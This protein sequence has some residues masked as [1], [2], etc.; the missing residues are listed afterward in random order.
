MSLPIFTLSTYGVS[1]AFSALSTAAFKSSVA[2]ISMPSLS[3]KVANTTKFVSVLLVSAANIL[4]MSEGFTC[5][6]TCLSTSY[7]SLIDGIGSLSRK[8]RTYCC[9]KKE[10]FCFSRL[11][12]ISSSLLR[13]SSL[14]RYSSVSVKPNFLA[15]SIST[16][17]ACTASRLLPAFGVISAYSMS[18][19]FE[20]M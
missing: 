3:G 10:F 11:S 8:W 18:F 15:L 19:V 7:S 17:T 5:A 2:G 6:A 1:S 12:Y 14:Q 4:E 9:T 13:N 20:I 16:I